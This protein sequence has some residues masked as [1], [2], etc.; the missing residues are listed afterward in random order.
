MSVCEKLRTSLLVGLIAFSL[1][2]CGS[3]G[4]NK[5]STE[6][7]NKQPGNSVVQ[8][9]EGDY[10][11]GIDK[12]RI[13]ISQTQGPIK[14]TIYNIRVAIFKPDESYK[15]NY[16]GKDTLTYVEM[17]Y[18]MENTSADKVDILPI[19]GKLLLDDKTQVELDYMK[20][21]ASTTELAGNAKIQGKYGFYIPSENIPKHF[22]LFC[23]GPV[24]FKGDDFTEFENFELDINLN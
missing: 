7:N 10:D 8:E 18:G 2:A 19:T 4:S 16:K 24:L 23:K 11:F 13:D 20:S 3:Q 22:K 1:T 6:Q 9:A 21:D 15:N 14:Y 5:Q 17:D 12:K